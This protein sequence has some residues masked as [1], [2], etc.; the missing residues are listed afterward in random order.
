MRAFKAVA[1]VMALI[2]LVGGTTVC[3]AWL[4]MEGTLPIPIASAALAGLGATV[5]ILELQDHA[6]V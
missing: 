3:C 1:I 2:M 6:S 4:L 5:L